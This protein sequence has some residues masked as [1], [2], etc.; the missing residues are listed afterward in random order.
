MVGAVVSE[1][2]GEE[3]Q[4]DDGDH[5]QEGWQG[6]G[7]HQAGLGVESQEDRSRYVARN[8]RSRRNRAGF[9]LIKLWC[10]GHQVG[11]IREVWVQGGGYYQG[12]LHLADMVVQGEGRLDLPSHWQGR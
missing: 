4:E 2:E 6:D 8:R 1:G 12:T 11:A 3:E 7:E 10:E 9:Y 5:H